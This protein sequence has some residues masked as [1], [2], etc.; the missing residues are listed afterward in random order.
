MKIH[1]KRVLLPVLWVSASVLTGCYQNPILKNTPRKT[2]SVLWHAAS[3]AEKDMGIERP[4][5][6]TYGVCLDVEPQTVTVDCETLF[7]KMLPLVKK[8]P[9]FKHITLDQLRDKETFEPLAE[10]YGIQV[11]YSVG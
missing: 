3:A 7:K 9:A 10:D 6:W 1:A 11:F 5:G 2:I 8:D 4:N